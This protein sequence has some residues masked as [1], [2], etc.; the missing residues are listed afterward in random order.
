MNPSK[1]QQLQTLLEAHGDA[2]YNYARIKVND[3]AVAADLVQDTF[4]AAIKGFDKFRGDSQG[5]TWLF[6]I[7]R[8]KIMDYYKTK[9]KRKDLEDAL[10]GEADL[11]TYFNADGSWK[12]AP[13]TD[14]PDTHGS[15]L[16]Q[17]EFLR[18]LYACLDKLPLLWKSVLESK[19]LL[20][21]ETQLLCQEL[22]LTQTNYWQINRRAKLA[23]QQCLQSNWFQ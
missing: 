22:K 7:L 5:R 10:E 3:T 20:E 13:K 4:E 18:V 16:D 17:P 2:L 6:G 8:H 11:D 14:V 12:N 15:L 23:M 21:K 1:R 19:Y 9:Y